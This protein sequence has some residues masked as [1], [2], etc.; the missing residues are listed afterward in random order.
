MCHCYACL[1][2]LQASGPSWP[3]N[4]RAARYL[5]M[6]SGRHVLQTNL[7]ATLTA[8]PNGLRA[9][10]YAEQARAGIGYP[11]GAV[12]TVIW[13]SQG[14]QVPIVVTFFFMSIP[15]LV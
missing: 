9:S 8:G 14:I 7:C 15:A 13:T 6:A 11:T 4:L 3:A 1:H 5:S 10:L 12:E 2:D